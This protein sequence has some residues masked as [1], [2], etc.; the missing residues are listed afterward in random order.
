MTLAATDLSPG[1]KV[2]DWNL[3]RPANREWIIEIML[4]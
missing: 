1:I 2:T 4:P 3:L